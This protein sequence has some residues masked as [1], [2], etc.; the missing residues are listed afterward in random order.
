MLKEPAT[1][2][3]IGID[4]E[5]MQAAVKSGRT[6]TSEK[7]YPWLDERIRGAPA[8]VVDGYPRAGNSLVPFAALVGSLSAS[9]SVFAL[10]LLCPTAVTHRRLAARNRADDDGRIARRDVEFESVQR[11][12]LDALPPQATLVTIDAARDP[13]VVLADIEAALGLPKAVGCN[14]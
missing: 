5:E 10:H 14:E 7:L 9:R 12:L 13:G 6:V 1:L 2:A 4:P 3:G 8:V 11:P